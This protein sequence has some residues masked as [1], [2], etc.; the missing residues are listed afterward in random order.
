MILKK[1]KKLSRINFITFTIEGTRKLV[2]E[3]VKDIRG[4]KVKNG[5]STKKALFVTTNIILILVIL[6]DLTSFFDDNYSKD[7]I[8]WIM[9]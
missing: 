4:I 5:K 8:G 9:Y 7:N 1:I 6:G 2:K 3:T